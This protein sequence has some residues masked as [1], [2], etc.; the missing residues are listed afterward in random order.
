M[1]RSLPLT[2]RTHLLTSR[3]TVGGQLSQLDVSC[4]PLP[5]LEPRPPYWLDGFSDNN[6]IYIGGHV[7]QDNANDLNG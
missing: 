1:F 2:P 7:K 5:E 4:P 3:G 6:V